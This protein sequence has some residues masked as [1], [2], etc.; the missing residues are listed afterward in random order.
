VKNVCVDLTGVSPSG[1]WRFYYGTTTFKVSSSK[2]AKHEKTYYDNQHAFTPFVLDNFS[3]LTL[4]IVY[5][6][7]RVQKIMHN[8]ITFLKLWIDFAIMNNITTLLLI[9]ISLKKKVKGNC[10]NHGMVST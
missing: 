8:N 1:S 2:I 6:F 4:E 3:F 10:L 9:Y 7:K 5:H